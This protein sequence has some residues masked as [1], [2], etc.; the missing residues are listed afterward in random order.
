MQARLI[1]A[2]GAAAALCAAVW[3]QSLPEESRNPLTWPKRIGDGVSKAIVS[4]AP[5]DA[6]DPVQVKYSLIA[7]SML[8]FTAM[9]VSKG[10]GNIV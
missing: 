5:Q 7:S 3:V 2:Y 8:I 4:I 9:Q 10:C 6:N 1:G